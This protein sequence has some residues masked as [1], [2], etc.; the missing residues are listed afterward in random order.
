M[1]IIHGKLAPVISA[2]N[3]VCGIGGI[4]DFHVS[5]QNSGHFTKSF[6]TIIGLIIVNIMGNFSPLAPLAARFE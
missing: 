1:I 5:G 4:Y 2:V 6:L 3:D